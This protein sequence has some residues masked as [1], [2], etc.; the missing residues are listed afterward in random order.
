MASWIATEFEDITF[1]DDRL[2]SRFHKV[3]EAF[4]EKPSAT[5]TESTGNWAESKAAY[6][7]FSN[8][9]VT[10]SKILRQHQAKTAERMQTHGGVV[11]AIQDTTYLD[12]TQLYKTQGLGPISCIYEH[13]KQKGIVCHNT[14]AISPEG[15]VFGLIDQKLYR[16]S[17]DKVI[18][19]GMKGAKK[20]KTTPIESKESY[21]WIESVKNIENLA[22]SVRVVHVCDREG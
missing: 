3:A 20:R 6:R 10:K 17:E 7:F 18:G 1:G 21:R 16:R 11:L 12:F 22:E 19:R 5:I 9:K 14:L 4:L 8:Q 15:R 13:A 2:D